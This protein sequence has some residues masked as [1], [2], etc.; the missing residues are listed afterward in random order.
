MIVGGSQG[1]ELVI[2][3]MGDRLVSPDAVEAVVVAGGAVVGSGGTVTSVVLIG[4][5][6]VVGRD[7]V[8]VLGTGS[9]VSVLLGVTV[10]PLVGT[11]VSE[12]GGSVVVPLLV[13]SID[14]VG[15]GSP[16]VV[17]L[18]ETGGGGS[19]VDVGG[20]A[21]PPLL[22]VMLMKR[23]EDV[24]VVVGVTPVPGSEKVSEIGAVVVAGSVP[25]VDEGTRMVETSERTPLSRELSGSN[26]PADEDVGVTTPVGARRI[27]DVVVATVEVGASDDATDPL[28][29]VE[30]AASGDALDEVSDEEGALRVGKTIMLGMPDEEALPPDVA[31][32]AELESDESE[33]LELDESEESEEVVS[34]GVDGET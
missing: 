3:E 11:E 34:V 33:E 10:G 1:S 5:G 25:L 22:N 4:M 20:G 2:V 32:S 7:T 30:F 23:S 13:G 8:D 18:N 31:E 21:V 16:G 17:V 6:I 24:G 28:V 12:T 15:V 27:P 26:R 19:T 29:A 14:W 9:S